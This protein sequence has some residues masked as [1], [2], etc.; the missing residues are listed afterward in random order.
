MKCP[1]LLLLGLL[2]LKQGR[3]LEFVVEGEWQEALVSP[4]KCCGVAVVVS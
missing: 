2:L 4:R 3:C 1:V